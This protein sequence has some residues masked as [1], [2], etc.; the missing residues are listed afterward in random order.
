[1]HGVFAIGFFQEMNAS[2]HLVVGNIYRH[3][4]HIADTVDGIF[5][6]HG[7]EV[8]LANEFQERVDIIQFDAYLELVVIG[9][10]VVKGITGLQ[11]F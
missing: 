2:R 1:M 7:D 8:C 6:L 5:S 3:G 10:H 11:P 4:F 9:H